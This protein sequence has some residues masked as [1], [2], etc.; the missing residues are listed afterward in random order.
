MSRR[1]HM[2]GFEI[3]FSMFEGINSYRYKQYKGAVLMKCSIPKSVD[4]L[5]RLGGILSLQARRDQI[6]LP[7]SWRL[8]LCDSKR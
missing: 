2:C 5:F 3:L 1:S 4:A 8:S 6:K 7:N